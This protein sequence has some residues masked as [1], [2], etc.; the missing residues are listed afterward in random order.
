MNIPNYQLIQKFGVSCHVNNTKCFNSR[1]L[2]QF[3]ALLSTTHGHT[4]STGSRLNM[5]ISPGAGTGKN[6][7]GDCTEQNQWLCPTFYLYTPTAQLTSHNTQHNMETF[8]LQCLGALMLHIIFPNYCI[9]L[10]TRKIFEISL[11]L[12]NKMFVF[13]RR[14][15]LLVQTI[16]TILCKTIK[17]LHGK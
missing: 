12:Q 8:P 3:P 2:N 14:G 11:A 7:K 6:R 5:V 10:S 15:T 9:L 17:S 1:I 13:Q 4:S 16:L